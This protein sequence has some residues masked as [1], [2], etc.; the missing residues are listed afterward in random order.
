MVAV[1]LHLR[2]RRGWRDKKTAWFA[3]LGFASILFTYIGVN[4]I[5]SGY[6]SYAII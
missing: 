4:T 1:Y 6:H 2:L 5:L 3:I